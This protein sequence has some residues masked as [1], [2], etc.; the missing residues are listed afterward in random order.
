MT[1]D[2]QKLN[3]QIGNEDEKYFLCSI[4]F[5]PTIYVS[6]LLSIP[7]A[8]IHLLSHRL[9][10]LPINIIICRLR[11]SSVV[12]VIIIIIGLLPVTAAGKEEG[13]EEEGGP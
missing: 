6:R 5:F 3:E 4:V 13:E 1:D 9:R 8:W 2:E 12:V 11:A 10:C 7:L